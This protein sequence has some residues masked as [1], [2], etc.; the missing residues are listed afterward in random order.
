MM[1]L[2]KTMGTVTGCFVQTL[3]R[4]SVIIL[5]SATRYPGISG[6]LLSGS[7]SNLQGFV[8]S[9]AEVSNL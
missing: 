2:P 4:L 1:N 8:S 3:S 6:S 7:P 9:P 5:V